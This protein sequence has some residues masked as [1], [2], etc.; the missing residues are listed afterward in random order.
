MD[1][2]GGQELAPDMDVALGADWRL[3]GFVAADFMQLFRAD[4]LVDL[5]GKQFRVA[6]VSNHGGKFLTSG[7]GKWGGP[8]E[9]GT[10]VGQFGGDVVQDAATEFETLTQDTQGILCAGSASTIFPRVRFMPE[11]WD[12]G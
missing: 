7:P 11:E 1:D 12:K 5:F 2:L 9:G 3:R 8:F 4:G 6:L 10:D